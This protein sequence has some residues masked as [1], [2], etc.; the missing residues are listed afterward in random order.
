MDYYPGGNLMRLL[1]LGKL[2]VTH[3]RQITA[4]VSAPGERRFFG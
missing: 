4:Q 3:A 1:S 2:G